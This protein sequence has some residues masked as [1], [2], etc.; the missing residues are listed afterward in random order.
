MYVRIASL[1]ISRTIHQPL[2]EAIEETIA[3]IKTESSC[4]PTSWVESKAIEI[5]LLCPFLL[6]H[7]QCTPSS[8]GERGS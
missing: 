1:I 2:D 8:E 7:H 6:P 3:L 5:T 4:T